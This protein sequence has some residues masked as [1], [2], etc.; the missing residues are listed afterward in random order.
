MSTG[1]HVKYPVFLSDFNQK[2][3]FRQ[4]FEE[5]SDIKLHENPPSGCRVFPSEQ[6]DRRTDGQTNRHYEAHSHYSQVSEWASKVW[7][8]WIKWHDP[9]RRVQNWRYERA[10]AFRLLTFPILFTFL[11]TKRTMTN[12]FLAWPKPWRCVPP[13]WRRLWT[14]WHQVWLMVTTETTT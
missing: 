8:Q 6:V 3:I 12:V 7:P 10:S 2:K 1:L 13:V 9:L 14:S 5:Y 4:I 11:M